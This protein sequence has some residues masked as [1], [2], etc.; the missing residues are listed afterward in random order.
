MINPLNFSNSPPLH[1]C[2][3]HENA[4]AA[5]ALESQLGPY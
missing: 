2:I 4:K 1:D 3:N 5:L